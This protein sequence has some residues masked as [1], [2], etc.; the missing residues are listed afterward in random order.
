MLPDPSSRTCAGYIDFVTFEWIRGWAWYP[1]HP[2]DTVAIRVLANGEVVA[3]AV[4]N[5]YRADV[6]AA[7]FG[8]GRYGFEIR[9]GWQLPLCACD[10]VVQDEATGAHVPPS[11]IRVAAPL[12]LEGA[13]AASITALFESAG[14]EGE[15]RRRAEFAA[16]QAD[17]LLGRLSDLRSGPLARA[18]QRARKWRWQAESGPEPKSVPPRAVVVD[19]QL[20]RLGRDA[21]SNAILSHVASL[22]RLGFS[23]LFVPATMQGG[24]DARALEEMGVDCAA[25][26]WFASVEE[27]MRREGNQ[28][29][30]LY[31]HRGGPASRYTALARHHMPRARRIYSVGDLHWLR[32]ARQGEHEDRPELVAH[33]RFVQATELATAA[34]C[35]AVVTHSG[36][37]A[38]L[39]R[40][41]LPQAL[42][43]VVPW[44]VPV[45]AAPRPF[46]ERR[47]IAFVGS[48]GHPPNLDAALWLRDEIMPMVWEAEPEITCTL[49]GTGMPRSL[50]QPGD[51]RIHAV[52]EV[53]D[54]VGLLGTVRLTVA[55]LAFGAG[56]KGKVMDSLAVGTPCICSPIAAEGFA[57]PPPLSDLVAADT[58]GLAAAIVRLHRDPV[59]FQAARDAGLRFVG[60]AFTEA[61][62]DAGLRRAAGLP[63]AG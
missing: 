22:R 39:L 58:A 21:G 35:H 52:G 37:E 63:A 50:T 41:L 26:P 38:D 34:A 3:R 51:P 59:L 25:E 56:L 17:K 46:A 4:A 30:L 27:V 13:A 14:N 6:E 61:A 29:D 48:Y 24:A 31:L 49:V 5:T 10:I 18:A 12:L 43:E 20:P 40:Q 55:P 45:Q 36:A 19:E 15:L 44:H 7:G 1:D 23:V 62:V 28:V 9:D 2:G 53:A 54:L 42:V 47:G 60:Q 33:A 16:A 8:T 11:P 57:L 32:L